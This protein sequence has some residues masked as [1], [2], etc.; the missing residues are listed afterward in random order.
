MEEVDDTEV[1]PGC[2][3]AVDAL[4]LVIFE[5]H[6]ATAEGGVACLLMPWSLKHLNNN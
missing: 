2:V 1:I 3:R 4:K 5:T 6:Q